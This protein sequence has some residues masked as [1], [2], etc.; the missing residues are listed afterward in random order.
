MST[1]L[2][3]WRKEL[4]DN[5]RDRRT[6]IL[7]LLLGPVF[8]PVLFTVML[9]FAVS[10]Q[11]SSAEERIE[12]AVIGAEH[13]SNLIEFLGTQR[14]DVS[15]EAKFATFD[16]AVAAVRNGQED[17]VA[18]IE[19]SFGR[20]L[21]SETGAHVGLVFDRSDSSAQ[22]SVRRVRTALQAYS[23]QIGSLRL[24]ARGMPPNVV[25][26]L[27]VD[28]FDVSTATGRSALLLG[29]ATYILLLIPLMGGLPVAIDV[30]AGERERKSLEPLFT[31]PATR[32]SLLFGK[33]AATITAMTVALALTLVGFV[34]AIAYLPLEQ[35]GMSSDFGLGNATLTFFVLLPLLPLA[36]ALMLM[37]ASFS[38][39]HKEAQGYVSLIILIPTLPLIF[40]A[41]MNVRPAM[42]LMFVPSLSQHLLV[43]TL[44]RGEAVEILMFAV[45]AIWTLLLGGLLTAIAVRLFK[46]EA[47]LA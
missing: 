21:E 43:T 41:I 3:V 40:A 42:E 27:I 47:F 10:Q 13:A 35:I 45:S 38:K 6:V 32:A 33:L 31:T 12:V 9:N 14:I 20:E 7:T 19:E 44:I 4:L 22:S 28:D 26:T 18:Y 37:V 8:G 46:R 5:M 30:T 15:S 1:T 39:T 11:I 29:T 25:Q 16:E 2:A 34:I 24:L 36:A 17:V 23:R